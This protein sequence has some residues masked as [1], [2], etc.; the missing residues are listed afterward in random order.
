MIGVMPDLQFGQLGVGLDLTL[1]IDTR[2]GRIRKVDW[3]DGAYRKVIRY[4]SWGQ[5]HD[6]LYAQVGQL[7]WPH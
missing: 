2:T 5:K 6:P 3:S 7:T 1:R 4:V